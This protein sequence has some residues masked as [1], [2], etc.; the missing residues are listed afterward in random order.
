MTRLNADS[1]Q[2]YACRFAKEQPKE[3]QQAVAE[4]KTVHSLFPYKTCKPPNNTEETQ[5][6]M[7]KD[8]P[9]R[10]AKLSCGTPC[11]GMVLAL[12][13]YAIS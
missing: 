2:I 11:C 4:M 3:V 7:I 5:A 1:E 8:V 6:K 9:L 13:R 12:D 10:S